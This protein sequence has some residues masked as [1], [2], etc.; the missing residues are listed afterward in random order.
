[1]QNQI[2]LAAYY[3][4]LKDPN[5]SDVE[6]WLLAEKQVHDQIRSEALK[7]RREYYRN[8]SVAYS[9]LVINKMKVMDCP[10]S[11]KRIESIV[12]KNYTWTKTDRDVRRKCICKNMNTSI[13][14]IIQR[15]NLRDYSQDKYILI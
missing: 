6:N 4:H 8:C 9:R 15:I 13:K 14:S 3:L 5:R 12:Q 7:R 10:S 2:E 1:M 11:A